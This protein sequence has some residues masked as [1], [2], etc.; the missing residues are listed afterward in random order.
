MRNSFTFAYSGAAW[1]VTLIIAVGIGHADSPHGN[2]NLHKFSDVFLA[3]KPGDEVTFSNLDSVTHN[4][5]SATPD[6]ELD[7]GELEPGTNK[8]LVFHH[9]G[10]VD[11]SCSR[12][13]EMTMTIFVRTPPNSAESA[14]VDANSVHATIN[15]LSAS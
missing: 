6:Y 14:R 8:A 3:L 9:K 5:V 1:L 2:Q 13:P 4:L 12:H 7:I 10:V 11:L 15:L